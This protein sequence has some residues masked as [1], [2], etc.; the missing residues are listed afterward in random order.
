M[1]NIEN[2]RLRECLR[3]A[4]A[5]RFAKGEKKRVALLMRV[6]TKKQASD[7]EVPIP[8]QREKL[9]EMIKERPDW[10]VAEYNGKIV[11]YTEVSSAFKVSRTERKML[12]K[13]LQD[14]EKDL[15]DVILFFK[16]DRLSRISNEYTSILQDFWEC[17]V[18]PWDYEKKQPLTLKSQI[19]KLIRFIE[20]WQSETESVNTSFRVTENM[21]VYVEDGRW[22]GG[23]APYGY[24]YCEPKIDEI[25][26][27]GK[28]KR[29]VILGIEP[30]L[31][32]AAN[33]RLIFELYT[34]GYG[35][36]KVCEIINN[37][38]YNLRKRNGKPFDP[39]TILK[40]I[41][42]PICIGLI[43]WGKTTYRE[44][45]F[46][47]V[48][49][50]N[51]IVSK[52]RVERLR[53][54]SDEVW[55]EAQKLL[56]ERREQTLMGK[57][58]ARRTMS[59]ER[60]LAGL[61]F[62]GACSEP[63]LSQTYS[64]PRIGYRREGYLCRNR[65]RK[66][67]CNGPGFIEKNQLDS[68]VM[69][70]VKRVINQFSNISSDE[71]I[72]RVRELC[73]SEYSKSAEEIQKIEQEIN[74]LKKLRDFYI[75]EYNKTITGEQAALPADVIK[76][77]V[78]HF[79]REYNAALKKKEEL[80]TVANIE[81]IDEEAIKHFCSTIQ[82]WEDAFRS[83]D[84][85][86]QRNTLKQI[87]RRID[88]FQDK[89][90]IYFNLNIKAMGNEETKKIALN[91]MACAIAESVQNEKKCAFIEPAECRKPTS[92]WIKCRI[93]L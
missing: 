57:T 8:V 45:Y 63:L 77:Q 36:T 69:K 72:K 35:S 79:Q 2:K 13:A 22:M 50:E 31:N 59:S 19:D 55:E 6:S 83:A 18:E 54:I 46:R 17:G 81:T 32:E 11:E 30:D 7:D 9:L 37:P 29:K 74:R 71:V 89:I 66:A 91:E 48:P 33:M 93:E 42:N 75:E 84:I 1:L 53:I 61:A 24:R 44:G 92:I 60:L 90:E 65:K 56:A 23:R 78:Q 4:K 26:R 25:A 39:A 58:V 80:E 43:T 52:V 12:K 3:Q 41:K 16:H 62:C 51:W 67:A 14:A 76:E 5:E 49:R 88:I 70:A 28:L 20:G 10:V 86:L 85:T 47:R 87:I 15:Y 73:N 82:S 64:T 21:E 38:P 40:I 34:K 68:T 27:S